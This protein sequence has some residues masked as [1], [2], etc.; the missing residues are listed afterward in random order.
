MLVNSIPFSSVLALLACFQESTFLIPS[1][2]AH[3]TI[4]H[5]ITRP[6]KV[7]VKI[8]TEGDSSD[9][10]ATVNIE[11]L[12]PLWTISSVSE[13]PGV[14]VGKSVGAFVGTTG[15]FKQATL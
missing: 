2:I 3:K 6:M 5:M 10:V 11:P 8:E 9:E 12:P 4:A 14:L 13:S 7:P 1:L 15:G